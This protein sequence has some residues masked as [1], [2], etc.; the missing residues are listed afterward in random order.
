MILLNYADGEGAVGSTVMTLIICFGILLAVMGLLMPLFVYE[1]YKDC[2][3]MR[4]IAEKNN[5]LLQQIH[6]DVQRVKERWEA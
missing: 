1:I 6:A 2:Q 5:W 4:K 3:R